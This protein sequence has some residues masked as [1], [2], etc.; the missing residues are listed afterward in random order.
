MGC[1]FFCLLAK[2]TIRMTVR[3]F[4]Q[5]GNQMAIAVLS[6]DNSP[7]DHRNKGDEAAI[8]RLQ[9][10][11][12]LLVPLGKSPVVAAENGLEQRILIRKTTINRP[13]GTR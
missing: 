1:E 4:I 8:R 9:M 13:N 3:K 6:N 11:E 5:C 2:S 10:A 12:A 7:D